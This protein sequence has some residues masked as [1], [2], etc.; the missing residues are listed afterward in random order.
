MSVMSSLGPVGKGPDP[1][2]GQCR[3]SWANERTAG[4][5]ARSLVALD[6][7]ERESDEKREAGS[8]PSKNARRQ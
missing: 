8:W 2:G 7:K 4:T 3:V 5:R 6:V 1:I